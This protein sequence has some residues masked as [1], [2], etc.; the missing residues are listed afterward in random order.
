MIEINVFI[1]EIFAKGNQSLDENKQTLVRLTDVLEV[2]QR[3]NEE[4]AKQQAEETKKRSDKMKEAWAKKKK[5]TSTK[6]ENKKK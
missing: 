4:E 5:G 3:L 1:S 2:V 6:K